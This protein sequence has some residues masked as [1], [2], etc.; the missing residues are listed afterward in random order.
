MATRARIGIANSDGSVTSIYAHWDG[1]PEHHAPILLQHYAEEESVRALI[2]LGDVSVLGESIGE[3]C[4]FDNGPPSGQ[5]LAY[6]R[7]RGE[8]DV[9]ARNHA[10]NDWPDSGQDYEYIWRVGTWYVRESYGE[11]RAWQRL[12]ATA[13]EA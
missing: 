7:D 8:E 4:D 2:E 1:Y 13:V 10:S 9:A 3:K 5:C 11:P 6:G 12:D